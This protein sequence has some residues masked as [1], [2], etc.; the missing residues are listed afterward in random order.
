MLGL[1]LAL[2]LM[3]G[4]GLSGQAQAHS[5]FSS[6]G[7]EQLAALITLAVLVV[8]W[9]AYT[10]GSWR[11]SLPL[12]RCWTFHLACLV[13]L[14]AAFGPLDHMAE[15]SAAAHMV[16][17][18]LFMVVIPPLWVWGNPLP[19]LVAVAGKPLLTLWQPLLAIAQRPMVAAYLHAAV[20]WLWHTPSLYN[21]AL[22]N[23][24]WHGVEHVCFIVTATLFWWSL[25]HSSRKQVP[26]A[27]IALL[28]TLVH[29][30]I[31]G[32]LLTFGER[33]F[34]SQVTDLEDQQLA[35]LLMWVM[36]G[37]PYLIASGWVGYQWLRRVE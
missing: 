7:E 31:L 24:W 8:L 21:L 3:L 22:W 19:P 32:A 6:R 9:L 23:P 30:G 11:L 18:M 20:I 35:G 14:L 26:L 17:H 36:G 34:Y 4:L 1:M 13:C 2:V 25:L 27:L 10:V 12:K 5:V 28:F 37:I 29:T 33:P 15:N 16:Q